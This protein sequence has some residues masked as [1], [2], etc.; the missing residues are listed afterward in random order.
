MDDHNKKAAG[1]STKN[2]PAYLLI[3]RLQKS[4]GIKGE[5]A[6]RVHTQFPERIR[7]GKSVYVGD[8]KGEMIVASIRWKANLLLLRFD[9]ID[10]PE[11]ASKLTNYEVFTKTRNLPKLPEGQYY[12]HQLI[13]LEVWQGD[14][15]LG[16]LT[17]IMETGANDVYVIQKDDAAELLIPA[18]PDV[19]KV[20]NPE[21]GIMIVELLEGLR[22]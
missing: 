22:D 12:H 10:N 14:E 9:G 21:E 8:E 15:F 16:E 7:A 19:I 1:S 6:M 20:I 4:H 18:I 11:A 13:G 17:D 2:E 3:G 5:I